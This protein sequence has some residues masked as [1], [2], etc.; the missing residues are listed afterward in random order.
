MALHLSHKPTLTV[1]PVTSTVH[2]R[3]I[4]EVKIAKM[5]DKSMPH[6]Y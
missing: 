2:P 1:Y 5:G 6:V 3:A 4:K